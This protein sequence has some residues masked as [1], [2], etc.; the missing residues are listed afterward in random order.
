[1]ASA[2]FLEQRGVPTSWRW[3][4]ETRTAR[5]FIEPRTRLVRASLRAI[6]RG[7]ALYIGMLSRKFDAFRPNPLP[8]RAPS[9]R[10]A[11][12]QSVRNFL[13]YFSPV[14][15][16]FAGG[17]L[18]HRV[19]TFAWIIGAFVGLMAGCALS[20][21]MIALSIRARFKADPSLLVS[22]LGKSARPKPEAS[23]K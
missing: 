20:V 5:T 1:M 6:A 17:V 8:A 22:T 14:V 9:L 11:H 18:G 10:C 23:S 21:S 15:G 12:M 3:E 2:D 7:S 4:R 19:H 13:F 16:A